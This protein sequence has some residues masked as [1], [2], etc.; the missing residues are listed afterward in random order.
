MATPVTG[1]VHLKD[2]RLMCARAE[3][4]VVWV[5]LTAGGIV[6]AGPVFEYLGLPFL[7]PEI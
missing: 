2:G 4:Q 3:A 5:R 6:L 7:S 1:L